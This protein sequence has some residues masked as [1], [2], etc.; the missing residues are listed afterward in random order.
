MG[1]AYFYL[2]IPVSYYP[3]ALDFFKKKI[4]VKGIVSSIEFLP[5]NKKRILLDEVYF[6][7]IKI[8]NKLMI[9]LEDNKGKDKDILPGDKIEEKLKV[10]PVAGLKDKGGFGYSFFWT[11]KNIFY[12]FLR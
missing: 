7:N 9:T 2:T 11:S 5:E 8:K 10:K 3:F 12:R 1:I 6:N 4:E